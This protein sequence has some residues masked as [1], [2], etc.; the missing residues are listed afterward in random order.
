[1]SEFA[2]ARAVVP[3]GL[4]QTLAWASSYYLPAMLAAPMARELGIATPTVF[5]AFSVALVVSAI[6]GPWC[7]RLIDHHGRRPVLMGTSG[8]FAGALFALGM[9]DSAPALFAA[10]A[11]MGIAMG[12]GLYEAAFASLVRLYGHDSRN[13]I[14]GITLCGRWAPR[15]SP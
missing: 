4:A 1:M 15:R 10:W 14:T 8:L 12:S 3:L 7:G 11:L 9:A 2:Q 5:A 13:A 6:V